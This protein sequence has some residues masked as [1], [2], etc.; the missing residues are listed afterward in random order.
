MTE[1]D[2]TKFEKKIDA[3]KD[4]VLDKIQDEELMEDFSEW[5][6]RLHELRE[7][8]NNI[9]HS[10]I[11]TNSENNEDHVFYNYR[12]DRFSNFVRDINRYSIDDLRTLN[13]SFIKTHNDG[14]LLWDRLKI[15]LTTAGS[16]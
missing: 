14:Y 8:R 11:L 16:L 2:L 3:L 6:T 13:Q 15:A 10:I 12:F 5:I 4:G 1:L 7:T 9:L